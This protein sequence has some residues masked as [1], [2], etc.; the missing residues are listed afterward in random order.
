MLFKKRYGKI[1]DAFMLK[2]KQRV[3]RSTIVFIEGSSRKKN[4]AYYDPAIYEILKIKKKVQVDLWPIAGS[5]A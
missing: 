4:L 5:V 3:S 2:K 1:R